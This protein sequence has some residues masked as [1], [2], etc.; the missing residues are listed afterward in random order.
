MDIPKIQ[1]Y[2]KD[3]KLDGWLMADFHGRNEI[4]VKMLGITGHLSRRSFYF[5]PAEGKPVALINPIETLQFKKVEGEKVVCRGYPM[6]ETELAKLLRGK[7]RIAMEYSPKGRLPYIGLVD[8][9]TIELVRESGVEIVSSQDLVADFQARLT[10]EQIA[11]HR[12]A[13]VTVNQIKDD[14]FALIAKAV[15]SGS[16]ITEADVCN[17]ILERFKA[18]GM[19]T[20]Y[21]PNC[22]VD[23][24]AGDPH[25][26]PLAVDSA[27]IKPHNLVL[28][29]LWARFEDA[30][31]V[32]ADIT[33]MA[34]TGAR[35]DIPKEYA[36]KFA[37]IATARDRAV[38]F[39]NE[40]LARGPVRGAEADDACRAVI[41]KA[42]L[43]Q[44]FRHRTGHSMTGNVHGEGPNI[45]N[46][47]TEDA[48]EL[49]PGHLFSIEPGVYFDDS[50]FRTEINCL[51]TEQGAEVTS[52]PL[53][54]EIIALL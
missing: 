12:K 6:L 4:A 40:R 50:G 42:G 14:A 10:P 9:G 8:A 26:D 27:V 20:E 41:E 49:Q 30:A 52:Q 15:K 3:N 33:W 51:I 18:N 7:N 24:H 16:A 37:L 44:Y 46:M 32:Y 43:G 31:G 48:R 2:L 25:Y 35:E 45:D 23:A 38:S 22:S 13:A 36:D 21:P 34:Y 19:I 1:Q 29:D 11:S 28:I 47:E 54:Q 5:I 53:Q 17:F 39:L